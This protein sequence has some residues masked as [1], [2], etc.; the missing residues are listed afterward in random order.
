MLLALRQWQIET[1]EKTINSDVVL[2]KYFGIIGKYR[3]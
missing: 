2:K 3:E 1:T